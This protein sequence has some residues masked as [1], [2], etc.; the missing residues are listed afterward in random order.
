[1]LPWG[2]TTGWGAR[3]ATS[4]AC[5]RAS[6]GT[7]GLGVVCA[8]QPS[9]VQ[10]C[11]TS[12][13]E[14][15][16]ANCHVTLYCRCTSCLHAARCTAT[17]STRRTCRGVPPGAWS[18][19]HWVGLTMVAPFAPCLSVRAAAPRA[20]PSTHRKPHSCTLS[21]FPPVQTRLT[22]VPPRQVPRAHPSPSLA[23]GA[24]TCC[25]SSPLAPCRPPPL[26][27]RQRQLCPLPRLP[28]PLQQQQPRRQRPRLRRLPLQQRQQQQQLPRR[29]QSRWSSGWW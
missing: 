18:L 26:H 21:C 15:C 17:A 8:V 19:C 22:Q 20:F 6:S 16:T 12:L 10:C 13:G 11:S 29:A 27:L 3:R 9:Q 7:G 23:A 24:G 5:L 2:R 4:T 1:M 14:L 25:R 28:L